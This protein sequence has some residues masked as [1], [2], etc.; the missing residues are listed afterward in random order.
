MKMGARIKCFKGCHPLPLDCP[1]MSGN[2][3]EEVL[4]VGINSRTGLIC[5]LSYKL[6]TVAI[7][8]K[9]SA[10]RIVNKI[11]YHESEGVV[12]KQ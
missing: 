6:S 4:I 10:D 5:A 3:K 9:R 8:K 11:M 2:D 1:V 12:C 7:F